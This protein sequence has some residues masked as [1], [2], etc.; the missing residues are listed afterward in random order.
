[1]HIERGLLS[2]E[3]IFHSYKERVYSYVL[4]I[5]KSNDAA[6]EVTQEIMI[7]LWL[8]REML[9]QVENLDAYIYVIARNKSLNHLRKVAY[10]LRLLN[11]LKSFIPDEYSNTEDR[12]A[13]KDYELLLTNAV[14]SLSP[15]RRQVYH[16]S[17]VEGLSHDEIAERLNLSKQTVKNHLVE[18]LKSIRIHLSMAGGAALVLTLYMIS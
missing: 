1:M 13:V 4:A 2:F 5:V 15:Q 16:L 14:N 6:E 3:Q 12:I 17:R 18:A 9:D 11:E 7:K 10:D 8:C